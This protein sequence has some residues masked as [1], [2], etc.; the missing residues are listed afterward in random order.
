MEKISLPGDI[1]ELQSVYISLKTGQGLGEL[2]L[3]IEEVLFEG[4]MPPVE[5][6]NGYWPKA[7]TGSEGAYEALLEAERALRK[8]P[9]RGY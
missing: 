7:G 8:W 6:D 5:G 9:A 1:S 2:L 3:K 4:G